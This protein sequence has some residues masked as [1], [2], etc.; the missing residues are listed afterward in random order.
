MDPG[1]PIR[2]FRW[3][4]ARPS[5]LGTLP[6]K[7]VPDLPTGFEDELIEIAAKV[8]V[9]AGNSDLVCVGRS[10]E[11]LFDLLAG[12]LE[13]T[14]WRDRLELLY[15]SLWMTGSY[16]GLMG[17]HAEQVPLLR[18]QLDLLRLGPLRILSESGQL[19]LSIS[20]P[21]AVPSTCSFECSRLGVAKR[22]STGA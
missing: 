4:I 17:R 6:A 9:R 8:V 22:A 11:H 16:E 12:L 5:E 10:P 18:R 7:D 13:G 15:V 19:P 20:S 2:P 14:S 1:E 21:K 3:N